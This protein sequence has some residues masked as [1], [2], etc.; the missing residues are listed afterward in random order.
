M[1]F[2][3]STHTYINTHSTS[4]PHKEHH[5]TRPPPTPFSPPFLPLL[6]VPGFSA[7][8]LPAWHVMLMACVARTPSNWNSSPH[9]HDPLTALS[10]VDDDRRLVWPCIHNGRQRGGGQTMASTS[11]D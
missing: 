11:E 5:T 10:T 9:T 2:K 3:Q 7:A 4:H 6:D 8:P 1:L